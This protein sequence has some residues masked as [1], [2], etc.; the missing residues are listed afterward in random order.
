MKRLFYEAIP[1]SKF[2]YVQQIPWYILTY[3][4]K[5]PAVVADLLGAA[6]QA[7]RNGMLYDWAVFWRNH[8]VKEAIG[9]GADVSAGRA[10]EYEYGD[11]WFTP[12][13]RYPPHQLYLTEALLAVV[14]GVGWNQPAS[15]KAQ[16]NMRELQRVLRKEEVPGKGPSW[17]LLLAQ[18]AADTVNRKYAGREGYGRG[19]LRGPSKAMVEPLGGRSC[20]GWC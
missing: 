8:G 1:S 3:M 2:E 15:P 5:E 16:Q 9:I 13:V 7:R 20:C 18:Q 19:E 14:V 17:Y 4:L 11:E 12:K 10:A 6:E